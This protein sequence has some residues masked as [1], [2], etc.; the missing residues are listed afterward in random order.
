M[1]PFG[2]YCPAGVK[3]YFFN[4]HKWAKHEKNT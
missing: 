3:A 1:K 4:N 2:D